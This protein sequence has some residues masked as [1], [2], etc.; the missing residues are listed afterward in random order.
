MQCNTCGSQLEP[1]WTHCPHCGKFKSVLKE[2][3]ASDIDNIF[4]KM[5]NKAQKGVEKVRQTTATVDYSAGVRQQVFEVIV[6]QA[7]A[8]APWREICAGPMA[9][10]NINDDEIMAEVERRRKT[11]NK[12]AS[13]AEKQKDEKQNLADN[14][15]TSGSTV[16]SGAPVAPFF[17][18]VSASSPSVRIQK[19]YLK[20]EDFLEKALEEEQQKK[21]SKR[22]LAELDDIMKDILRLETLV[23]TIETEIAVN[24]DL[25]RERRRNAKPFQP[26]DHDG[27]PHRVDW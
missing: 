1:C 2:F 9:V 24:A 19:L 27:G 13:R 23:N 20:L 22:L 15:K 16:Q 6:R 25:E 4:E 8:G 18:S 21:Y 17:E 5:L 7:L 10:N 11:L 12:R 3:S 26:P 14:L